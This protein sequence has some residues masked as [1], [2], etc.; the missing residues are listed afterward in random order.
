MVVGGGPVED[1]ER[2]EDTAIPSIM[3][4]SKEISMD[5]AAAALSEEGDTPPVTV[6]AGLQAVGGTVEASEA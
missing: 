5:A 3:A 1:E 6:A 4:D 2:Q